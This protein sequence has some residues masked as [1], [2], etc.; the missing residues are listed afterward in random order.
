MI[1]YGKDMVRE[2]KERLREG[3]GEVEIVHAFTR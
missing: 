1:R 2:V 3:K